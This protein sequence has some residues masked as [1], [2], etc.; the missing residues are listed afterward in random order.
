M[1]DNTIEFTKDEILSAVAE[2]IA[3]KR[4]SVDGT[5]DH[6]FVTDLYQVCMARA[7]KDHTSVFTAMNTILRVNPEMARRFLAYVYDNGKAK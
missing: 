5:D 2:R 6:D 1:E 3:L 4:N 7:E